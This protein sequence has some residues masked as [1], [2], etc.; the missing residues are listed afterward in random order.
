MPNTSRKTVSVDSDVKALAGVL[1][2][3]NQLVRGEMARQNYLFEM[4]FSSRMTD[5][6]SKIFCSKIFPVVSNRLIGR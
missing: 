3:S 1:D 6:R 4:T 2:E 5:R